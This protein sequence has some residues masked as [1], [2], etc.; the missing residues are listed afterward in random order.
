MKGLLEISRK[1]LENAL[2]PHPFDRLRTGLGGVTSE[3]AS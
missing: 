3:V 2:S 1:V